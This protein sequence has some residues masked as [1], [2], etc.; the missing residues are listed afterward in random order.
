MRRPSDRRPTYR[1]NNAIFTASD[2]AVSM[3][4]PTKRGSVHHASQGSPPPRLVHFP[5][6]FHVLRA[7]LRALHCHA[8]IVYTPPRG[9]L[10]DLYARR[11]TSRHS[12]QHSAPRVL[13]A[14]T[15]HTQKG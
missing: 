7:R 11:G 9:F 3:S 13:R 6:L 1:P 4:V 2:P 12:P 10:A 5:D 15:K 14:L 8:A